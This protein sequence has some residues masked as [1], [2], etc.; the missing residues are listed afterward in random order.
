MRSRLS[1]LGAL[2]VLGGCAPA[3]MTRNGDVLG[4]D[5]SGDAASSRQDSMISTDA[6]SALDVV[7]PADAGVEPA[8]AGSMPL[9]ARAPDA[10]VVTDSGVASDAAPPRPSSGCGMPRSPGYTCSTM[11]IAGVARQ[12]CVMVPTTYDA[13]RPMRLRYSLHGCGGSISMTGTPD[14]GPF[15]MVY[16][17]SAASCWDQSTTNTDAM[18]IQAIQN[19]LERTLCIDRG[20]IFSDGFSSGGFQ[21]TIMACA[22]FAGIRAAAT[23]GGAS[24]CRGPMALWQYHGMND[25]TVSYTSYGLA[26]RN[27]MIRANGCSMTTRPVPGA[28][29]CVEYQGCRERTIWCTDDGGHRW[30]TW[31]RAAAG[32]F[33]LSY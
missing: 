30:P 8:D 28:S 16:P 17:K 27:L 13:N 21:S 1:A 23:A 2:V 33:F 14:A 10:G 11:M 12:Y 32:E 26:V 20:R 6:P 9:D 31:G 25:P 15:I 3:D 24:N 22:R 7:D 19:E 18:F 29:A 5:A 4:P